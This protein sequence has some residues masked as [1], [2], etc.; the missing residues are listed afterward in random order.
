MRTR[1]GRDALTLMALTLLSLGMLCASRVLWAAVGAHSLAEAPL[2]LSSLE[3]LTGVALG[4]LGAMVLLWLVAAFACALGA[5][6]ALALGRRRE[7]AAL[8]ALVPGFVA[9]LTLAGLSGSLALTTIALAAPPAVAGPAVTVAAGYQPVSEISPPTSPL[10]DTAFTSTDPGAAESSQNGNELLS[11]GWIPHRVPLPLQRLLGGESTRTA[12]EVVVRPG[13]S[14]WAIAARNLPDD[15]SVRDIAE[16]WPRWY[17][18][19]R[20]LIG[21]NP[22]RLAVGTILRAPHQNAQR[23]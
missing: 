19:N 11:P 16:A 13:D 7:S 14:L 9:R 5:R 15:A 21:S 18:A 6:L 10:A 12:I 22:N 8:A 4:L 20:Q 1:S 23:S 17:E 3:R 2:D